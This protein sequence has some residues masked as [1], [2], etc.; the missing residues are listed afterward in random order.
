[1]NDPLKAY[2]ALLERAAVAARE[3]RAEDHKAMIYAAGV[4]WPGD[5]IVEQEQPAVPS[6]TTATGTAGTQADSPEDLI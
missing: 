6:A 3:G 1:M 2:T 4:L 5:T